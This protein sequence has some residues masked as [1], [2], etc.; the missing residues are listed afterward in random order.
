MKRCILLK[1]HLLIIGKP[2]TS[3]SYAINMMKRFFNLIPIG[4]KYKLLETI[5]ADYREFT[6]S[7][8][9]TT[10]ELRAFV[11]ENLIEI[12]VAQIKKEAKKDKNRLSN[13]DIDEAPE[14]AKEVQNV[15]VL[16][17]D[18]IGKTDQSKDNPLK[19][20][21]AILDNKSEDISSKLF[22]YIYEN[23]EDEM[24]DEIQAILKMSS[25][26]VRCKLL[27]KYVIIATSNT[28]LDESK[29][30]RFVILTRPNPT[31]M[32]LKEQFN[33]Q[34]GSKLDK[35]IIT[36][37]NK[38]YLKKLINRFSEVFS[39]AYNAFIIEMSKQI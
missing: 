10:S 22:S 16:F 3:K 32:D 15:R 33:H 28:M 4:E 34:F 11:F 12:L 7:E 17:L 35:L 18:E 30:N 27:D 14:T 25:E 21:H 39:R 38:V 13:R 26:Q 5:H 19:F 1:Q 9:T 24:P 2:G 29:Q 20:F 23:Y 8:T 37:E 31:E 36:D 6:G